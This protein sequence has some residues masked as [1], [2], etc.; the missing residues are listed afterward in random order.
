MEATKNI[1]K[2]ML[3]EGLSIDMIARV[4]KLGKSYGKVER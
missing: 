4:T 3:K 1:T 2:E